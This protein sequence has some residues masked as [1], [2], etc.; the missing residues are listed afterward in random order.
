MRTLHID[1]KQVFAKS[2]LIESPQ[3]EMASR[4]HITKF[5]LCALPVMINYFYF[6]EK[7][8]FAIRA[9]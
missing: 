6:C 2:G 8:V 4:Q 3:S 9:N 5:E 7:R 1:E